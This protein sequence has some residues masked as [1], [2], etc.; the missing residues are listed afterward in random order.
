MEQPTRKSGV[1]VT[2]WAIVVA[3]IAAWGSILNGVSMSAPPFFIVT[4]AVVSGLVGAGIGAV[5][6]LIWSLIRQ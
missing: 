5:L 2:R 6:G 3:C 4:M 1:S